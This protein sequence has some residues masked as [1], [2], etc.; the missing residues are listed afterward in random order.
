MHEL[1]ATEDHEVDANVVHLSTWERRRF[2]KRFRR[3]IWAAFSLLAL[4]LLAMSLFYYFDRQDRLAT[5]DALRV[6]NTAQDT[7]IDQLVGT[8]KQ[9]QALIDSLAQT[10]DAAREQ[11]ANVPSPEQVAAQVPDADVSQPG[12]QGERGSV[13]APGPAGPPGPQGDTGATGLP[14]AAGSAGSAGTPGLNGQDGA[15]GATGTKGD[16]GTPGAAGSPGPQ[17]E[18]GPAPSDAQILAAV[19]QFCASHGGCVGP[20]GATGEVGPAGPQGDPG[21]AGPQGE[22]GPPGPIGPIG[23]QGPGLLDGIGG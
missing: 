14:G 11:G 5:I 17:G 9:Q 6:G 10:V 16:T 7:R 1:I 18:P 8:A 4:V 3:S 15:D 13:G 22:Q 20:T 2:S 12:P 19:D 23:P 21:P